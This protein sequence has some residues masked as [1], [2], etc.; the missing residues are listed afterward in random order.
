MLHTDCMCAH[1]VAHWTA[2]CGFF[3]FG[4]TVKQCTNFGFTSEWLIDLWWFD[5]VNSSSILHKWPRSLNMFTVNRR[6]HVYPSIHRGVSV[7]SGWAADATVCSLQWSS[8]MCVTS[9][10]CLQNVCTPGSEFT[11]SCT[12]S[13]IKLYRSQPLHGKCC[14]PPQGL[15]CTYTLDRMRYVYSNMLQ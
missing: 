1:T 12:H 9:L 14:S 6:I 2:I 15:F 11:D 5:I 3:R 13:P 8:H 7:S 10:P 4:A